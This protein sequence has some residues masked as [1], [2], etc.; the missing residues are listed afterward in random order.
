MLATGGGL[1][2]TGKET[3]EFIALDADNGKTLWRSS[4]PAPASTPRH[5]GHLH[6]TTWPA[7]RHRKH[8][9][10]VGGLTGTSPRTQL[11]NVVPTAGRCGP[12]RCCRIELSARC[13]S[14]SAARGSLIGC[15]LLTTV[16]RDRVRGGVLPLERIVAG[17]CDLLAQLLSA[18][19]TGTRMQNPESA[20]WTFGHCPP[21][22]HER[23]INSGGRAAEEQM[24][25]WRFALA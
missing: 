17:A 5:A 11:K 6:P 9:A 15:A 23:F 22:Q 12:S 20:F 16:Q 2:F 3:G 4:R 7:I 21:G 13:G 1:L 18:M 10:G 24:P 14:T 8:V 19:S 25:P